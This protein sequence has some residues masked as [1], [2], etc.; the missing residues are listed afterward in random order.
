MVRLC[1]AAPVV[2]VAVTVAVGGLLPCGGDRDDD[3]GEGEDNRAARFALAGA[4]L[5]GVVLALSLW[6]AAQQKRAAGC[7]CDD[8]AILTAP[9]TRRCPR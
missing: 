6:T 2:A 9:G 5:V 1:L 4:L 7:G 3:E 8:A